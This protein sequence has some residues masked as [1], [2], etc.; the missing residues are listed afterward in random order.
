MQINPNNKLL[1]KEIIHSYF[2]L[3]EVLVLNANP[4]REFS[5]QE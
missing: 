4:H 1:Y 3:K 2:T 5:K